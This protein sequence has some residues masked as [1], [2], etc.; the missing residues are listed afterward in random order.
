MEPTDKLSV[1]SATKS[2][3]LITSTAGAQIKQALKE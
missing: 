1:I 3:A 2:G